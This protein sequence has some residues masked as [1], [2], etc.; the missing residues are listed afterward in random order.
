LHIFVY[1]CSGLQTPAGILRSTAETDSD[2]NKGRG[3]CL[4]PIFADTA[5]YRG[6]VA[7]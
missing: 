1:A 7:E 6:I 5:M 3:D 2:R 4:L